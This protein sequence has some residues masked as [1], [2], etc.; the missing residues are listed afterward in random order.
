[1][2]PVSFMLS[3]HLWPFHRK[4]IQVLVDISESS[5]PPVPSSS[6][7]DR[8]LH[9]RLARLSGLLLQLLEF[10]VLALMYK[11]EKKSQP[12]DY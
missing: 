8:H 6:S 1:M 5:N 9:A 7:L 10:L 4:A 12:G 2:G 3:H 11:T